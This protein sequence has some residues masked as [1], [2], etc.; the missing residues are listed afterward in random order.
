MVS[1][2]FWTAALLLLHTYFFYPVILF[3]LDGFEQAIANLRFIRSGTERRRPR[4]ETALP[5]VSLVVAA[6]NE[7]SCIE[8]KLRRAADLGLVPDLDDGVV[9]NA[10]PLWELM[11]FWPVAKQYWQELL[12]GKYGWSSVGKHLQA[13]G[14]HAE[15]ASSAAQAGRRGRR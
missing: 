15:P 1:A 9:L 6:Y 4:V 8:E 13:R 10:A 5:S 11:P 3:I 7:A 12:R 14:L 2:I